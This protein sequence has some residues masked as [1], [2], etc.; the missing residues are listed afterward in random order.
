MSLAIEQ[1]PER[2]SM[3]MACRVLGLN[4]SSVYQRRSGLVG[5][6]AEKR[7]RKKS[8]QPRALS[9]SE[10]NEVVRELPSAQ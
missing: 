2:L 5:V 1:R 7:C 3:N 10:Y 9:E 6:S 8:L 4:R